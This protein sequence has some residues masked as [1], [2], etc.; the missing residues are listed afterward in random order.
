MDIED[1]RHNRKR[2]IK[3][4]GDEHSSRRDRVL[5]IKVSYIQHLVLAV[6]S[7]SSQKDT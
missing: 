1:K 6:E 7:A 5:E 4:E 3:V 2:A